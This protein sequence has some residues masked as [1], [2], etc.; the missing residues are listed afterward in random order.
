MP[1]IKKILA[2]LVL[3]TTLSACATGPQ[4]A[5][6]G[7]FVAGDY[8]VTLGS[9]WNAIKIKTGKKEKAN[10]L[11]KDGPALNAVYLFSDI[12][13]GDSLLRQVRKDVPVPIFSEDM[14]DLELVEFLTDS[15]AKGGGIAG[16]RAEN[17]RP[18]SFLGDDAIRFELSGQTAQGLRMSGSALMSSNNGGLDIVLFLAPTE[19][20]A[21]KVAADVDLMFRSVS[22]AATV[23][24][25][26]SGSGVS[27]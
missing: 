4:L 18:D 2:S 9:D 16:L 19:Y 21:D 24:G 22:G 8:S 10:L 23:G 12:K 26:G 7:E 5:P 6:A 13:P 20:Y 1:A 11:T 3:A 25:S 14:F 15:L 27:G 17:V